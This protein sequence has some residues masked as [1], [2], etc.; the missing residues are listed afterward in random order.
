MTAFPDDD[1]FLHG[2]LCVLAYVVRLVLMKCCCRFG[3]SLSSFLL[4]HETIWSWTDFLR[5]AFWVSGVR[6]GKYRNA[7]RRCV[8]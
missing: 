7:K 8:R 1:I 6:S 4:L 5:Y 2:S 3:V